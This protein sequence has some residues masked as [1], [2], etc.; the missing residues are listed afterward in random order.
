MFKA[1]IETSLGQRLLTLAFA[2]V[3][4]LYGAMVLKDTPVEVFPDLNKPTITLLTEAGGMAPSR[5]ATTSICA[6]SRARCL[7]AR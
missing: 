2:L 3:L 1:I 4:M 5:S 7:A 6:P